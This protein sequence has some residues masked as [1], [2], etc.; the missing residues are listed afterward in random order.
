M[1]SAIL[2]EVARTRKR[3]FTKRR[4]VEADPRVC[5]DGVG[6]AEGLEV[7]REDHL[8]LMAPAYNRHW[9]LPKAS[10]KVSE[11]PKRWGYRQSC[12]VSLEIRVAFDSPQSC[13]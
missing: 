6:R 11:P 2:A 3:A 8:L 4:I 12:A 13:L 9:K 1:P 5:R 7:K 10:Q